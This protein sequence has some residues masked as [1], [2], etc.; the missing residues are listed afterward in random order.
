MKNLT[1]I[2]NAR[3]GLRLALLALT[4]SSMGTVYA[5]AMQSVSLTV[6]NNSTK[7]IRYLY[8]SPAEN[9]NWGA[10]QLNNS[11]IGTGA[12]RTVNFNWDP[13]S[14][15]LVAEDQDGCFLTKTVS[16]ASTIEWTIT[17]DSPRNCGH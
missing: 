5:V 17:N 11:A 8:L 9:E 14:V 13:A 3:I 7:E 2:L 12:T 16:V 15:K 6:V 1:T 10:D 4:L